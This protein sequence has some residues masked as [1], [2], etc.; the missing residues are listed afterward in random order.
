MIDIDLKDRKILYELDI[1]S[2]QSFSKIGK[3][4]GLPKKTVE[5]RVIQL[6]DKGII[7]NFYTVIDV[8]KL[9]YI[10]MRFH[11]KYQ[12][13]SKE[14]EEEIINYFIKDKNSVLIASCHGSYN[15]KVIRIIKNINKFYE[16]WNKVQNKYGYYFQNRS[17]ALFIDE[18]YYDY[19]FLLDEIKPIRREKV[20]L[21]GRGK[22]VEIDDFD[23]N[24]LKE[25]S[26][27]ARISI[28]QLAEILE[29]NSNNIR[30]HITNLKKIGVIRGYRINVDISKLDYHIFRTHILLNDYNMRKNIINYIK[31]NPNLVFIDT[32][33]GQADLEFEFYLKNINEYHKIMKELSIE[34][35]N[36][37]KNFQ[38]LHIK[39]Y[40][41]FLYIPESK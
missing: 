32:Y 1:N 29:T 38:S 28:Y 9:G 5:D 22:R 21:M 26:A 41:K 27:N 18:M 34:F 14:L 17:S 30:K 19:S 6:V 11:Y 24:L 15:L 31:N 36:S 2:R 33:T 37:I 16:H 35:P 39:K 25:I 10:I 4:V 13:T 12:Y 20:T 40:H 3:K 23:F 8:Y 7:K